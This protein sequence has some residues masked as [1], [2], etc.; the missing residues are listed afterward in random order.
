MDKD[1]IDIIKETFCQLPFVHLVGEIQQG[2]G[3]I[4]TGEI[5][6][7]TMEGMEPLRWKMDISQLYPMKA[8][9]HDSIRFSNK[10]LME[11]S[12]IM[13]DANLC[14]HSEH[15][16]DLQTKLMGDLTMLK[17]WVDKYYVNGERD[18]HYEHL[19]VKYTSRR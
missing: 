19:I 1:R 8:Q 6:V 13:E 12:H 4:I 17:K 9:G 3:G 11:Y 10:D 2:A 7:D 16:Y 18:E 14:L 5:D 15:A